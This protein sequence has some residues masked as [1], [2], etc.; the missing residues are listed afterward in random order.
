M[1]GLQHRHILSV[2][3][4]CMDT[5]NIPVIVYPWVSRGNLKRYSE[6]IM[7]VS[8]LADGL[9]VFSFFAQNIFSLLP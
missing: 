4:C 3:G 6:S 1:A 7:R 2:L 5:N 8:R 9:T